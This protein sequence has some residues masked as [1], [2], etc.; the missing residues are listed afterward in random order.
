ML[1]LLF[2]RSAGGEATGERVRSGQHLPT[3][4]IELVG[5]EHQ[6]KTLATLAVLSWPEIMQNL[7]LAVRLDEMIDRIGEFL[8][9]WPG[10]SVGS[11]RSGMLSGEVTLSAR[12]CAPTALSL[13]HVGAERAPGARTAS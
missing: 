4:L 12:G 2:G 13:E 11:I 6:E 7:T 8:R 3:R 5:R 9:A 10:E 1:V